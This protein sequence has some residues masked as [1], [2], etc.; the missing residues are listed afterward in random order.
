LATPS[1]AYDHAAETAVGM[2]LDFVPT[3]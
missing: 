3:S 1:G 2:S